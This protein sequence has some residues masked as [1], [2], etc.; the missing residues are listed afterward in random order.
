MVLSTLVDRARSMEGK[1]K[2]KWKKATTEHAN[3]ENVEH[4]V[5]A[6][7]KHSYVGAKRL[8]H[9]MYRR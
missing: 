3:K 5:D 7:K 8:K 1:P 6:D 2:R 4:E 9:S